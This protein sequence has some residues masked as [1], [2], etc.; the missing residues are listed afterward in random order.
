ML[1]LPTDCSGKI[2]TKTD[3]VMFQWE[4]SEMIVQ[5]YLAHQHETSKAVLIQMAMAGQT[6]MVVG[7]Q[8]SRLWEKSLHP[9]GYPT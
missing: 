6:N 4:Q 3:L 5:M 2:A 8:H 7:M 9:V 1:S